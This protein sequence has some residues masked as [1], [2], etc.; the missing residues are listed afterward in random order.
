M[1]TFHA[2]KECAGENPMPI[3][4]ALVINYYTATALQN[5]NPC[6]VLEFEDRAVIIQ[7]FCLYSCSAISTSLFRFL[8]ACPT[9]GAELLRFRPGFP[10][11][12]RSVFHSSSLSP[13]QPLLTSLTCGIC[14]H[15]SARTVG[16][17]HR[18]GGRI[19]RWSFGQRLPASVG[20]GSCLVIILHQRSRLGF[21]F[22][23]LAVA[24][25]QLATYICPLSTR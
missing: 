13:F 6:T 14:F 20:V 3:V 1:V 9:T 16:D 8:L 2:Q 23:V 22:R 21:N 15:C 24:Y 4:Q 17:S 11:H 10:F 12:H 19:R 25:P 5:T 7:P 18:E